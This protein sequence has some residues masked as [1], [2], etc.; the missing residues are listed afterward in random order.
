MASRQNHQFKAIIKNTPLI[1]SAARA[2]ARAPGVEGLRKRLGFRGSSSYWDERYRAGG[3]SGAGSYGRLAEFKAEILNEFVAREQIRSV[4]EFGCGDGAQLALAHYPRYVGVD[5]SPASIE[6]CTGRFAGDPTKQFYLT[7]ALPADL[8]RFDLALSLDVIY[9]LV[10]DDTF[11][12][13]MRTLFDHGGRHVV[14][15][16]SNRDAPGPSPHVRHR[17]FASWVTRCAPAWRL[18]RTIANRFPYD[19]DRPDDTSFADFHFFE[20]EP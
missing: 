5:V 1:G 11:E 2:L 17:A 3:N 8:G 4:I 6:L 12:A 16:A 14:I 10:E 7:G 13:Y 19:S 9:H 15:Y 18:T 20:R